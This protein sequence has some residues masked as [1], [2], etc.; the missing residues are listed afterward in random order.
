MRKRSWWLAS[1]A[2]AHACAPP[3]LKAWF[4]PAFPKEGGTPICSG[5]NIT[6]PEIH[7]VLLQEAEGEG[8]GFAGGLAVAL[9][10][11]WAGT[12]KCIMFSPVS[13][14]PFLLLW[15]PEPQAIIAPC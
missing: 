11:P 13:L 7:V 2:A 15:Y 1:N 3:S 5:F 12:A 6:A 14:S 9:W 8:H 10:H 4:C